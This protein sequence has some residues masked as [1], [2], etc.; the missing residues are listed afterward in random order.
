[1]ITREELDR[2]INKVVNVLMYHYTGPPLVG[3]LLK[4][5]G[6]FGPGHYR[7][8]SGD[9]TSRVFTPEDVK[10]I[11]VYEIREVIKVRP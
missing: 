6:N 1:M 10:E 2:R 3:I 7:L 8:V 11:E 4:P 5:D 9:W